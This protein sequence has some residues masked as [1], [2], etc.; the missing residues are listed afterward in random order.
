MLLFF[1][2]LVSGMSH[3]WS[4]CLEWHSSRGDHRAAAPE[5]RRRAPRR[6]LTLLLIGFSSLLASK[7][8][9][10]NTQEEKLVERER[11]QAEIWQCWTEGAGETCTHGGAKDQARGAQTEAGS[12]SSVVL[13]FIYSWPCQPMWDLMLLTRDPTYSPCSSSAG[14]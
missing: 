6:S 2:L 7:A 1:I 14:L 9:P 5:T 10:F 11:L 4:A 8:L 13:V 12:C 3:S